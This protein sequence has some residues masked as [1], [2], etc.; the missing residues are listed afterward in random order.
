[1]YQGVLELLDLGTH[2]IS[3]RHVRKYYINTHGRY[4]SVC[5]LQHSL[6]W[7]NYL[8]EIFPKEKCCIKLEVFLSARDDTGHHVE[9][10][11]V[12]LSPQ[13]SQCSIT[14]KIFTLSKMTRSKLTQDG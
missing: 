11:T 5:Q 6:W 4:R 8:Y 2:F 3:A 7:I 1:M 14:V 9:G 10:S 13:F 12:I